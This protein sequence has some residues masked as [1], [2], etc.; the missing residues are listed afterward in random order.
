MSFILTAEHA[1]ASAA[2]KLV[3]EGKLIE[4]KV[5]PA[6]QKASASATVIEGITSLVDPAAVNVER[7]A[8]AGLG[9]I[10]KA[11]QDAE[12]AGASGGVN[13]TLDAAFVADVKSIIPAVKGATAVQAAAQ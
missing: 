9:V 4:Q 10:I 1:I 3:S 13:L 6:L 12:A 2:Q 7:A 11:I 5:L 8:Y